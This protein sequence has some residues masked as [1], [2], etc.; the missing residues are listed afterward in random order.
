VLGKY[1]LTIVG[2]NYDR[3]GKHRS[4]RTTELIKTR[5]GEDPELLNPVPELDK[6]GPQGQKA[7]GGTRAINTKSKGIHRSL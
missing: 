4:Q 3:R 6:T 2:S 5:N 1:T 7:K